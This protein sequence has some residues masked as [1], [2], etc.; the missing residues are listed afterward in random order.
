MNKLFTGLSWTLKFIILFILLSCNRINQFKRL[1]ILVSIPP[2]QS[3]LENILIDDADYFYLFADMKFPH[4]KEWKTEDTDKITQ[5]DYWVSMDTDFEKKWEKK[6]LEINPNIKIIHTGLDIP[7][8]KFLSDTEKYIMAG[9][10][11]KTNSPTTEFKDSHEHEHKSS[12]VI[13]Q[14]LTIGDD[15]HSWVNPAFF[16][17]MNIIA[18]NEFSQKYPARSNKWEKQLQVFFEKYDLSHTKLQLALKKVSKK[19]AHTFDLNLGYLLDQ[20]DIAQ[21]AIRTKE[22]KPHYVEIGGLVSS[23]IQIYKSD[24]VFYYDQ[25]DKDLAIAATKKSN[26][27]F[28]QYNPYTNDY[29]MQ[30]TDVGNK[31][32]IFLDNKYNSL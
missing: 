16:K 20:F 5:C 25:I 8:R 32:N 2:Q 19:H 22:L 11:P 10:V 7:K 21:L 14:Y 29:L 13:D 4:R 31:L 15:W 18:I 30:M 6:I 23:I 1:K 12:F 28:L 26:A 9:L 24:L 27:I 3:I 17:K